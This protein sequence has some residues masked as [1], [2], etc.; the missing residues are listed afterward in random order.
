MRIVAAGA[1]DAAGVHQALHEII[2]LHPVLVRSAI[3][4]MGK[5]L[6]AEFMFFQFPEILEVFADL[7]THGQS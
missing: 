4:E 2:A 6:F 5:R 7:E 3:G 1:R